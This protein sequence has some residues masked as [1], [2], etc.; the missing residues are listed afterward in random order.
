MGIF[1]SLSILNASEDY[2]ECITDI[3]F[4]NGPGPGNGL[5]DKHPLNIDPEFISPEDGDF[6]LQPDSGAINAGISQ[7]ITM[8]PDLNGIIKRPSMKLDIGAL[9][10]S[11]G[12]YN[13]NVSIF[14]SFMEKNWSKD[15]I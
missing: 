2:S 15:S 7:K 12:A 13:R 10:V 1:L 3:Y 6:N 9:E 11:D 5:S 8:E 4:G 14:V